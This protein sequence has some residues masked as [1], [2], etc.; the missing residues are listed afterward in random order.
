MVSYVVKHH[1][2]GRIRIEIPLL[3]RAPAKELNKLVDIP[4]PEGVT[5]V[6][7]NPLNGNL[8][9]AYDP[10][11]IDIL[12]WLDVMA[13]DSRILEIAKETEKC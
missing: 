9:I 13:S 1:I 8:I 3:K 5:N 4:V 7:V 11:R 12:R 6:R 2:P 10:K